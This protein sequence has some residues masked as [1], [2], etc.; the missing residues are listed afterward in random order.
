[1][2]QQKYLI[3]EKHNFLT[4]AESSTYIRPR[5]PPPQFLCVKLC[6]QHQ[7]PQPQTIPL[8]NPQNGADPVK[9]DLATLWTFFCYKRES[10][11]TG[12]INSPVY[13]CVHKNVAP[14]LCCSLVFL[15]V[16]PHYLVI[17]WPCSLNNWPWLKFTS[18]NGCYLLILV[19]RL[20]S[21]SKPLV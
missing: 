20:P 8:L 19:G 21:R 2:V 6:H 11:A 18:L 5:P 14:Y 17:A 4:C 13:L 1:M 3:R 15:P 9:S 12:S 16:V 10:T 7:Q